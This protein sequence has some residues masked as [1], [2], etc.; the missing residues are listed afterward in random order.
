MS[1]LH[2]SAAHVGRLWTPTF[3]CWA[4]LSE[5]QRER[6]DRR[7]PN[8]AIAVGK[9]TWEQWRTLSTLLR[10]TPWARIEGRGREGDVLVVRGMD[11][12]HVGTFSGESRQRVL[13]NCGYVGKDGR[14]VGSV[15]HDAL[16]DLLVAGYSRPEVWRYGA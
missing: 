16:D 2:W 8:L 10:D 6:W 4:F 15:R 14:P 1:G 5:L 3:N 13:H 7:M 11:G 12:P 9:F